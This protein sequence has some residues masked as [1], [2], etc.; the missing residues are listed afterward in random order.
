M[1]A[2]R[3]AQPVRRLHLAR[4]MQPVKQ[5]LTMLTMLRVLPLLPLLPLLREP[6]A[7]GLPSVWV[8]QPVRRL[9]SA[10]WMR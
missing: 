5:M 9:H 4:R 3:L 2:V 7:S 6:P 1:P 8:V 10:R